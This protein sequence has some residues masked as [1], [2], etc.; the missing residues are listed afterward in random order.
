MAAI[1]FTISCVPKFDGDYDHM[2]LLV[3][4]LLCFKE[5]QSV[6]DLVLEELKGTKCISA[7]VLEEEKLKDLKK[8][9]DSMKVRYQGSTNN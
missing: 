2:S 7:K 8:L 5:Y 3:E 9:W 6:I 4:N 1:S